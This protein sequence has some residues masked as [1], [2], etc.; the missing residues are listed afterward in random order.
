MKPFIDKL[1]WILYGFNKFA[2]FL[3]VTYLKGLLALVVFFAVCV[4]PALYTVNK[5]SQK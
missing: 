3:L 5:K 2:R 1:N 4:G